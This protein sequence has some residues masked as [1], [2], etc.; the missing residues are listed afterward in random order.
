M[1]SL[2]RFTTEDYNKQRIEEEKEDNILVE[3]ESI[4]LSN[5]EI[6]KS[7]NHNQV[8]SIIRKYIGIPY[9]YGGKNPSGFDCS[10]FTSY[11]Y[12]EAFRMN[13]KPVTTEQY[14]LGQEISRN[15][16]NFGDLIFFNTT[17]R[18]PSHVGIYVR[19]K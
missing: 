9:R 7:I 10:G 19:K 5:N 6:N 1:T 2:P 15:K 8:Y 3:T 17:G 13:I 11:I 12:R 18:I 4:E 16:L 14:R